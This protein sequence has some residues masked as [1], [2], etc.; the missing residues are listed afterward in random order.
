MQPDGLQHGDAG[1]YQCALRTE[2]RTET[3][4]H[5]V[6]VIIQPELENKEP[7]IYHAFNQV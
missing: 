5:R 3:V 1:L 2:D 4:V 6:E 7:V